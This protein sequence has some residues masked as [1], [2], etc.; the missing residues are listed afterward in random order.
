MR[1]SRGLLNKRVGPSVCPF[2]RWSVRPSVCPWRRGKNRVS[3]LLTVFGHGEPPLL[4]WR[5]ICPFVYRRSQVSCNIMNR[6]ILA[7]RKSEKRSIQITFCPSK[8]QLGL[9]DT[10]RSTNR[11]ENH[12]F[13][14][15]TW[16]LTVADFYCLPFFNELSKKPR[17]GLQMKDD[18]T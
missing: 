14:S 1:P 2:F 10:C 18:W 4:F 3:R 13:H 16:Q 9:L 7:S 12:L 11:P 6:Y 8:S 17:I 15:C 5:F